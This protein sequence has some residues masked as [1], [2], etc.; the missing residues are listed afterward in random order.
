MI[1][2]IS[3]LLSRIRQLDQFPISMSVC[4]IAAGVWNYVTSLGPLLANRGDVHLVSQR[5]RV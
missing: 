1:S 5:M 3:H 2:A 4:N